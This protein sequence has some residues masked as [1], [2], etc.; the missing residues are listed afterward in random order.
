MT[1]LEEHEDARNQIMEMLSSGEGTF[2]ERQTKIQ[3]AMLS[4]IALSLAIIADA[5]TEG[6]G[7]ADEQTNHT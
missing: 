2:G 3:S 4:D 7:V 5:L 6:K 1:R